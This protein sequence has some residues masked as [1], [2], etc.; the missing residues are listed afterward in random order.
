[1]KRF[2]LRIILIVFIPVALL[3]GVYLVTDPFK[4]LRPFSLEYFDTTNRD[5]LS[6]ELFILNHPEQHYDS[7]V[8]GSSRCCGINSYHWK[9]YLE[10]GSKQFVFQAWGESLTGIEQKVKFLDRKGVPIR[11]ALIVLDI[12][13]SFNSDQLPSEA[14][15]IKDWKISGQ[16]EILYQATLFYDFLQKPSIWIKSIGQAMNQVIVEPG[17][18]TVSN[19]WY[20]SNKEADLWVRPVQDSLNNCS[21]TSRSVF[22]KQIADCELEEQVISEELIDD[23]FEAQLRDIRAVFDKHQTA[24]YVIISPAIWQ[25]NKAINPDDLAKLQSIFDGR[26]Y[27]FSGRNS[28]TEDYN[29]FSDPNHFGLCAGWEMIEEIYSNKYLG[30][31]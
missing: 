26:V 25:L 17:F 22:I 3:L 8:F 7:F 31:K 11:N 5:Y 1:M 9:Q 12:P 2:L 30:Y 4:T 15:S 28:I 14:L 6:S 27:D 29:N 13:G 20:A 19:D 10:D 23:K 24:F 16:S 18:D 21:S